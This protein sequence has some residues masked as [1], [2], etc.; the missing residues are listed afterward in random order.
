MGSHISKN[1]DFRVLANK[2]VCYV[3]FGSDHIRSNCNATSQ[4]IEENLRNLKM[5]DKSCD[6][7]LIEN[8]LKNAHFMEIIDELGLS[9]DYDYDEIFIDSKVSCLKF[10]LFFQYGGKT[11]DD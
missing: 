1:C 11:I 3:C 4:D 6:L 10:L 7:Q 5:L 8:R 2:K 9:K